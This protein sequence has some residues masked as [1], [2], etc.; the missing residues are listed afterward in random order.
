MRIKTTEEIGKIFI[1]ENRLWKEHYHT[2]TEYL[3]VVGR[4]WVSVD[5]VKKFLIEWEEHHNL[6][7]TFEQLKGA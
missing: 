7:S 1:E 3:D 6:V 5:D 4:E 2:I